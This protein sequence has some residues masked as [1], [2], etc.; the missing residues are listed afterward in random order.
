MRAFKKGEVFY[1][2][3]IDNGGRVAVLKMKA[4]IDYS[5]GYGMGVTW[6]VE[7]AYTP[8]Y[9]DLIGQ[10]V[11]DSELSNVRTQGSDKYIFEPRGVIQRLFS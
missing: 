8:Y 11:E 5:G 4:A 10:T 2:F 3:R 1:Y 7:K 6:E 9:Q